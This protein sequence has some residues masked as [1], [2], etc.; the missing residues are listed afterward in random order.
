MQG[1]TAVKTCILDAMR[2]PG[3]L[4]VQRDTGFRHTFLS[5]LLVA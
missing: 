5:F 3:A 1:I 2:V 4:R